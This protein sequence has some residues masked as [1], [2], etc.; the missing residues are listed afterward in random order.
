MCSPSLQTLQDP[1]CCL[2]SV[3]KVKTGGFPNESPQGDH[4]VAAHTR[5][6]SPR[7]VIYIDSQVLRGERG[8]W[9]STA[10]AHLGSHRSTGG[11][12]TD[13]S[14]FGTPLARGGA[15][16]PAA[17]RL[18]RLLTTASP[19][20]L[21][22]TESGARR[23]L[24]LLLPVHCGRQRAPTALHVPGRVLV[25]GRHARRTAVRPGAVAVE[26]V[27]AVRGPGPVGELNG[28][29]CPASPPHAPRREMTCVAA[30]AKTVC[31]A[32][33]NGRLSSSHPMVMLRVRIR[34]TENSRAQE[35]C[36]RTHTPLRCPFPRA[37]KCLGWLG[38][39]CPH[40]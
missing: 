38:V 17:V 37:E 23:L 10:S 4:H 6:S 1:I 3:F 9:L 5:D 39:S 40:A 28:F 22:A 35:G 15:W 36:R 26:D 11:Q 19:Q 24:L 25:P 7:A 8:G 21:H 16:A 12:Q 29:I 2:G 18:L 33:R 34:H 14:T 32:S 27:R 31:G 30:P 20:V 13:A